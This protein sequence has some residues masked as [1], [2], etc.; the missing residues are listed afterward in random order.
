MQPQ[1]QALRTAR[2][3]VFEN[4]PALRDYLRLHLETAGYLVSV[5]EDSAGIDR[6]LIGTAPDLI[7][8]GAGRHGVEGIQTLRQLRAKPSTAHL[9][10]VMVS[11]RSQ[12]LDEARVAG[13]SA[14]LGLPLT[15]EDLLQ[16]VAAQLPADRLPPLGLTHNHR[17]RGSPAVPAPGTPLQAGDPTSTQFVLQRAD[18]HGSA[19]ASQVLCTGSVLFA[20][21]RNFSGM[22]ELLTTQEL[23]DMLN[24]Y[25][26]RACEPV[27][28]HGGWVVKL[29][30]D[31]LL[32]LF[33]ETPD[34][35]GH[36]ERALKTALLLC[37]VAGRFGEWLARRFPDKGLPDFA[38]GVGVHSGDVMICRLNTGAGVD[39]TIIGDTVNV[40]SRLEEQ[41][42]KLG[43]SVVTSLETL[44]Q[45][46]TRFASGKRGSLLVRGRASPV[47]MAEIT[48]LRPRTGAGV[49]AR[50]AD[51]YRMIEDAVAHNTHV[52]VRV[53]DRLLNETHRI[54]PS[55]Q[56]ALMRPADTPVK[57]PGFRL[58]R[59]LGQSGMSRAFLA[60]YERTG[61]LRVLKVV[62]VSNGAVDLLQRFMQE[63]EM[64]SQIRNPH[65]ATIFD[66]GQSEAHAYIVMEYFPGGDLRARMQGPLP[67]DTALEYVCQ[68]A[69]A[70]VAIHARGIVHRDLKPDNI[71]LREDG[72]LVL[73]DFGIA[74]DL[75]RNMNQTTRGEG[76]GTPYYLSPEQAV[77]SQVDPRSDLYSL[78]VMLYELLVGEPPYRGDDPLTV[79]QKHVHAPLPVLPEALARFQPVLERLMA[80]KLEARYASAEVAL[81]AIRDAMTG[82]LQ[83]V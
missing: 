76:L 61:A 17:R 2:V 34:S 14:C 6:N 73:T 74:K 45:A 62:D 28:Q 63:V 54:R 40:A 59:R 39:T 3:L 1:T 79:L 83:A 22:A 71:M 36:A 57:V 32:A 38:V 53:R 46:G 42:K 69:E 15:R 65:V 70:L 75:S 43:A 78:G 24:A 55:Q 30:G 25:F 80:K 56:P 19:L 5:A 35:P 26:V 27:L 13:A 23:A 47:E 58:V 7:L 11:D 60:E 50:G 37:V 48:G 20:D 51:T 16:G 72:S 18:Q 82:R 77:S 4:T 12:V 44:G 64:I 67:P 68:I 66:H 41:T 49:D 9:P 33:E 8:A 10:F 31:G 21:I 29:L 52:I 81:L